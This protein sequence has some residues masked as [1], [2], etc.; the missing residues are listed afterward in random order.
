MDAVVVLD[1]GIYDCR[2]SRRILGFG[3]AS[4]FRCKPDR[5]AFAVRQ[6]GLRFGAER[7]G[8]DRHDQNEFLHG[9]EKVQVMSFRHR[10]GIRV[11]F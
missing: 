4:D 1:V 9:I 6:N 10:Y 3:V 2:G 7:C 8:D 5:N 11:M